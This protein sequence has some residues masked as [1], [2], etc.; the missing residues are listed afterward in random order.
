M[1]LLDADR[2]LTTADL[3]AEDKELNLVRDK[4]NESDQTL[5]IPRSLLMLVDEADAART[6]PE[7]SQQQGPH[8]G[9]L[10]SDQAEESAQPQEPRPDMDRLTSMLPRQTQ[11]W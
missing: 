5:F 10:Q 8:S 1:Q 6:R 3:S 11:E 9:T 7:D 4:Q 2:K